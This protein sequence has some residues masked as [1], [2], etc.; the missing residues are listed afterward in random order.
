[1][2]IKWFRKSQFPHK[3]VKLFLMLVI[4]KDKLTD[5]CRNRLLQDNFM[6]TFC[7]IRMHTST[8]A[9]ACFWSRLGSAASKLHSRNPK[10]P[11]AAKLIIHKLFLKSFCKSQ[12]PHKSVNLSPT[13]TI[14]KYML[15]DLCGN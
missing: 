15:T 3:S 2:F 13:I 6:N 5:L 10:G 11:P 4:L 7:K 14:V 8:H 1:M 12:S 9:R